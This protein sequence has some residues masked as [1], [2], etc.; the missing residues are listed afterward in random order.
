[1]SDRLFAATM[2]VLIA[3]PVLI[4]IHTAFAFH[5]HMRRYHRDDQS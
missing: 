5:W 2:A 3:V 4:A 1:M